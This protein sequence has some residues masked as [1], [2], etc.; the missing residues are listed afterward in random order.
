M[1]PRRTLRWFFSAVILLLAVDLSAQ[2]LH[3][4]LGVEEPGGGEAASDSAARSDPGASGP[5]AT[6][7]IPL[8]PP[9]GVLLVSWRFR[10][11]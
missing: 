3:G 10:R 4:A 5:S 9:A 7:S 1:M 6:V 2:H 11:G 8:A